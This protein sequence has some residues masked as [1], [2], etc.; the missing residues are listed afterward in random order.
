MFFH[1]YLQAAILPKNG[2]NVTRKIVDWFEGFLVRWLIVIGHQGI[3]NTGNP[4]D[5]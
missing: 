1:V 5:Q 2:A 3:T 4:D